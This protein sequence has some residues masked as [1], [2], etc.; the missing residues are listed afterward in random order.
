MNAQVSDSDLLEVAHARGEGDETPGMVH[1]ANGVTRA[2]LEE[3]FTAHAGE[4]GEWPRAAALGTEW[5]QAGG[6]MSALARVAT[7]LGRDLEGAMEERGELD[8]AARRRLRIVS[9]EAVSRALEAFCQAQKSRRDRWLS[10]FA[11]EMRNSLNTLVNAHWILRN[12]EGKN[13]GKVSDMAERAVRKLEAYVK[14]F[15]ELDSQAQK[16]APG[17]PDLI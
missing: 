12:G 9:D 3:L 7:R 11:H 2:Y 1:T 6:E 16:P 15:R 14:E 4:P 5:H 10:Y 13:T 17:R 8:S